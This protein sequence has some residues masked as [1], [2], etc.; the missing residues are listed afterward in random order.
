MSSISSKVV[1]EMVEILETTEEREA[2]LEVLYY[3][4]T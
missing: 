4:S 2:A 1:P 3:S